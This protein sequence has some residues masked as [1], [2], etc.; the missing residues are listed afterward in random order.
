MRRPHDQAAHAEADEV[1]RHVAPPNFVRELQAKVLKPNPPAGIVMKD[2][3]RPA[4]FTKHLQQPLKP[5]RPTP[6]S[7]QHEGEGVFHL[8]SRANLVLSNSSTPA[9]QTA[10]PC[11]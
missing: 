4:G 5:P 2:L 10:P 1:H 3:R 9:Y 11:S 7:I 8:V 6:D